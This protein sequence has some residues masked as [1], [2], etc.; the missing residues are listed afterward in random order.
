[1]LS[2]RGMAC[3]LLA[4][5]MSKEFTTVVVG[6]ARVAGTREPERTKEMESKAMAVSVPRC[7]RL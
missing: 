6:A 1:M 5:R 3:T 2:A 7:R 4:G